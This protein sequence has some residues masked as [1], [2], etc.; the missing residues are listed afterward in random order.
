MSISKWIEQSA[1]DCIH[2]NQIKIHNQRETYT[3]KKIDNKQTQTI[4]QNKKNTQNKLNNTPDTPEG[5][6]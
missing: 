2:K 5:N 4:H 3:D 1:N 6:E